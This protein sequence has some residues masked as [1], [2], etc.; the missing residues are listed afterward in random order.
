MGK[1][2][3]SN[4]KQRS[5]GL[6]TWAL[7]LIISIVAAIVVIVCLSSVLTSTGIIPRMSTAMQ[8]TNFKINQNMMDYF[9]H[10]AYSN[11]VSGSTYSAL[12]SYCSLNTGKNTGLALDKQIIGEGQYDSII[13]PDHDGKTWHQFFLDIA[14][15]DAKTVLIFCEEAKARS[16]ELTADELKE[17]DDNIAALIL[18]IQ[19]SNQAYL[20]A[21][22]SKCISEAFGDGV[23]KGDV[24]DAMALMALATKIQTLIQDELKDAI[25]NDRIDKE[26][27]ENSKK[28]D[29]VDFFSYSFDVKY[30]NISKEVL[31]SIGEDAKAEDHEEEILEAYVKAINEAKE[32]AEALAAI[33]DKDEFFKAALTYFLDE[34]YEDTY[35]EKKKSEKLDDAK[36]PSEEDEAKIKEAMY[37]KLFEELLAEDRKDKAVDDVEEKDSKFYAYG[38][39]VTEEYG[40]FLYAVKSTL[41]SDLVTE[42]NYVKNE[43]STYV[44]PAEDEEESDDMKWLFDAARKENETVIIEDGDGKDDAEIKADKKKYSAEVFFMV[45]P[46]YIDES[47][48][49][50]GAYMVFSSDSAVKSAIEQLGKLESVDME[51]FLKV[52]ESLGGTASEL[53][54]YSEGQMGSDEFDEWMFDEKRVKGDYTKEQILVGSSSYILAYFE[55]VSDLSVWQ[56]DVK[57][58]LLSDDVSAEQERITEKYSS[59]VVVKD[60][61]MK[62]VGK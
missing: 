55:Q 29:L 42:E 33:T 7:T 1:M 60:G 62:N 50:D 19:Y 2:K 24:K 52:A 10:N 43:E 56:A 53:E 34:E 44:E 30:D 22:D 58:S 38:V 39:E 12:S 15:E 45:K 14:L 37:A 23:S 4:K 8:S 3:I 54:S 47:K 18:S 61:V 28:Y 32:K 36:K 49:R 51:A 31:A 40:K 57:Y 27:T 9:Y 20:T 59:S 6:P 11:F 16:I 35:S 26:Y 46:R 48:V 17:L 25:T 41:Y 21:S 5:S 13:A